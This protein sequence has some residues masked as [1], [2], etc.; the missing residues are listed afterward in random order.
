[1]T[2]QVSSEI[3]RLRRVLIHRPGREI[4]WMVPSMME[5]LLFEDILYSDRARQEH[6]SFGQVLRAA[7]VETLEPQDLLAEVL[8]DAG[9]RARLIGRM[10]SSGVAAQV[11]SRLDD[12]EPADLAASLVTGIPAGDDSPGQFYLLPPVPNY[13]F[14]R[15]PQ[16]V[17][18]E[19]VIVSS[20]AT[21]ARDRESLLAQ[22]IFEAHPKLAGYAALVDLREANHGARVPRLEGGDVLI[23]SPEV[24]LVGLSER[25]NRRGIET[26][27]RTLRD[28]ET[29]FRHLLVV[30]LPSR[31]S[32]MHLDT[33]LTFIDRNLCLAY[34]P[35]IESGGLEAGDVY[36]VDLRASDL[37]YTVCDSLRRAL[38]R[39]GLEIELV[40]CGGSRSLIDQQREQWTDGANAFALAPGVITTYRRN[41]RTTEELARRGWRVVPEEDVIR[42]SEELIGQG[43]TVVTLLDNELSRARGGPRCMTMPLERDSL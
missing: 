32:Y 25:T 23:P 30:E 6:D 33:V 10:L 18:G 22:T 24:V 41:R 2:L 21:D 8:A 1:M 34:L 16:V 13:F 11:L 7:G 40:P 42:G 5:R 4:D 26:L 37:A 39:V 31:R 19:R 14:Q 17:I 43:P 36:H 28:G 35:V 20:M 38:G 15:D 9:V 29:T 3:G 12:L 27:A